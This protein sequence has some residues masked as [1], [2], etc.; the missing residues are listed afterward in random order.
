M[1]LC[2]CRQRAGRYYPVQQQDYLGI[3]AFLL[4]R[5]HAYRLVVLRNVP[6]LDI[7]STYTHRPLDYA[8]NFGSIILPSSIVYHCAE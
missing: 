5:D 2:L 4:R 6:S 7:V 1:Q 3:I 8:L